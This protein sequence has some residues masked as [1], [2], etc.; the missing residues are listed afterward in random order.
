MLNSGFDVIVKKRAQERLNIADAPLHSRRKLLMR[1]GH[2]YN[3]A[4][5]GENLTRIA[6]P[7]GGIGAGMVCLEGTGALSHLSIR[8]QPSVQRTP[9]FQPSPSRRA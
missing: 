5:C 8:N 9:V 7:M 3:G 6:F 4:Y 1:S 2:V